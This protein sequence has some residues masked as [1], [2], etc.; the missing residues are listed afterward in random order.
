MIDFSMLEY[1]SKDELNAIAKLSGITRYD[2]DCHDRVCKK[3]FIIC[4]NEIKADVVI[5]DDD[6]DI[7][8]ERL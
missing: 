5:I 3:T 7:K 8:V 2:L 1:V 6:V 4:N